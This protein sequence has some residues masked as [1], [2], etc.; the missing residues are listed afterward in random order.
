MQRKKLTHATLSELAQQKE[1][2]T[3]KLQRTFVGG[4]DGSFGNPFTFDE[5]QRFDGGGTVYYYDNTG[6]LS[7]N[8][9]GVTINGGTSYVGGSDNSYN[10]GTYYTGG[11]DNYQGGTEGYQGGTIDPLNAQ[12]MLNQMIWEGMKSTFMNQ[13]SFLFGIDLS[14]INFFASNDRSAN[15]WIG[16]NNEVYLGN[17]FFNLSSSEQL[18]ILTHEYTHITE[19]KAWSNTVKNI[20]TTLPDPPSHIKSYIFSK[21]VDNE[22]QY[23]NFLT[24]ETL[25]DPQYYKNEANAYKREK[26]LFPNLSGVQL[27]ELN[28][29][30]WYYTEMAKYA[31]M[32]Y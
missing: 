8:L 2:I 22:A 3:Y 9:P 25:Y 1:V 24:Y 30:I 31:E 14:K 32:Y 20:H 26:E 11:T 23:E 4:G 5:Y 27:D 12:V 19:D 21:Y 6:E 29:R 28:Y 17:S 13:A 10:G 15:A 7:C 16:N 18:R